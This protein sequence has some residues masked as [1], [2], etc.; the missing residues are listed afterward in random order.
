[1]VYLTQVEPTSLD[2]WCWCV[3]RK[4]KGDRYVTAHGQPMDPQDRTSPAEPRFDAALIAVTTP[5]SNVYNS[6]LDPARSLCGP[7]AR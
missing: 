2:V 5:A 4:D 7:F 3:N 6:M 1:M